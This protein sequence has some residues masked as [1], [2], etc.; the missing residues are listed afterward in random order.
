M[1][2]IRDFKAYILWKL[3]LSKW[4]IFIALIVIVPI[5]ILLTPITSTAVTRP[6]SATFDK[7][8][9]T[10]RVFP[11]GDTSLSKT[12]KKHPK[13]T[14]SPAPDILFVAKTP[15]GSSP[16]S[17]AHL[18]L[19][20]KSRLVDPVVQAGTDDTDTEYTFPCK[21]NKPG[22]AVIGWGLQQQSPRRCEFISVGHP[23]F[24]KSYLRN[25]YLAEKAMTK[26]NKEN[27]QKILE[28]LKEVN[29]N[30][31]VAESAILEWIGDSDLR[32]YNIVIECLNILQNQR[33]KNGGADLDK[34]FYYYKD[35][36][37]VEE[38]PQNPQI[39]QESLREAIRRGYNN[40]NGTDDSFEN[41]LEN[42]AS[43]ESQ[44]QVSPTEDLTLIYAHNL[45]NNMA[46]DVL[47]GAVTIQAADNSEIS[48]G[49]GSRYIYF[50]NGTQ[51]ST[52]VIG[53][54]NLVNQEPVQI[55]L[56]GSNWSEDITPLINAF[57]QQVSQTSEPSSSR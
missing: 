48:V 31:S 18:K 12:P 20:A 13:L 45:D 3:R 41:I 47:V 52:S 9:G 36:L 50:G 21:L 25:S 10:I 29:I 55:F 11:G 26:L 17:W 14:N 5:C 8:Q 35:I 22:S 39:N 49:A 54:S 28:K 15:S 6:D 30:Y 24:Q 40:K 51:G 57:N 43:I 2:K 37:G 16:K 23:A 32:Y 4:L 38:L 44:V 33:L 1:K 34:I 46:I 42:V 53:I 27:A 19:W 56:N 7:F